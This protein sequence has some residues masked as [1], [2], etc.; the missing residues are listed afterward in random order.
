MPVPHG[1][2]WISLDQQ[3]RSA[4]AGTTQL[5]WSAHVV[6]CC[7]FPHPLETSQLQLNVAR[8]PSF[9]RRECLD[10]CYCADFLATGL[11]AI[12][13][14]G[15]P[16]LGPLCGSFIQRDA[17]MR[18]NL[19][20]IAI[21]ISLTSIGAALV[22]ETHGTTIVKRELKRAVRSP[23]KLSKNELTSLLRVALSR[24]FIYLFTEPICT[25]V[26]LYLAIL[27]GTMYGFFSVSNVRV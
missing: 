2:L 27:Y 22:P 25:V 4:A 10:D 11:D 7:R 18:W 15:G 19:R 6:H 20:V 5:V 17:G 24:P 13:A 12:C 16:T 8:S 14:F 26:C 1:C 3:C 23:P 9:V 21:Y